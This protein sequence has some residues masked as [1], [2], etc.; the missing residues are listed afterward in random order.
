MAEEL[1]LSSKTY[2]RYRLN[3]P[4]LAFAKALFLKEKPSEQGLTL[5]EC[6]VAIIIVA[7]IISA[8]TPPIFL[9]VATRVQNRKADQAQQLAQAEVDRVRR[10]V[11]RGNYTRDKLPPSV[12]GVRNLS[13]VSAPANPTWNRIVDI[14]G[15]GK[16]DFVV[17]TF[18]NDGIANPNNPTQP[19]AFTVGVRVYAFFAGQTFETKRAS[20]GMTTAEGSQRRRPLVVLYNDVALNDNQ[21]SLNSY[22]QFLEP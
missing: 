13:T 16:Q 4:N 9:V 14:N 3:T 6:L 17:Q 22:R 10:L 1:M 20:L 21:N 7:V 15:D 5:L 18:R 19:V 8:I 2:V 12:G 11:E